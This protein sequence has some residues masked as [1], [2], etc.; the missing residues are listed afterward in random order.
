MKSFSDKQKSREVII[1][2]AKNNKTPPGRTEGND[3]TWK[4]RS[5]Q[6]NKKCWG[7]GLE[8]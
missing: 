3:C 6:G 5:M 4:S 1:S 7:C 2:T 8:R